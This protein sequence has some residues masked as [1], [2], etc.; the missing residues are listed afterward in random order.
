MQKPIIGITALYDSERDSLWMLPGYTEGIRRAGGVPVLL[1]PTDNTADIERLAARC[2][3]LLFAGGQDVSPRLYGRENDTGNVVACE[4]R[5]SFEAALLNYAI[6]HDI[7]SLGICRGLQLINAVLGGSL[8]RDLRMQHP[9]DINHRQ[10]RPYTVPCH[11]VQLHRDG[12]LFALLQSGTLAVNSCHHQGIE[13][14][15]PSL[16]VMATAPDGLIEAVEKPD[17]RFLWAVQWHPEMMPI[18]DVSS[19]AVFRALIDHSSI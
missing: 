17:N 10:E 1:P 8:Y 11:T 5:D 18:G 14:L 16:R 13:T 19:Q 4:K 12:A 9:S 15:A 3:G 7:P 6:E 2:D